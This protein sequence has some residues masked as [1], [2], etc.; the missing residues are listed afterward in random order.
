M[1]KCN[2]HLTF[3]LEIYGPYMM[4]L[5]GLGMYNYLSMFFFLDIIHS[6]RRTGGG[7]RYGVFMI[8]TSGLIFEFIII[9]YFVS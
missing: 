8:S 9:K 2:I 6:V 4:L 5:S 7:N 3:K 1:M